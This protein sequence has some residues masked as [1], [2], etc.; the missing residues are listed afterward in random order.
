VTKQAMKAL[1]LVGGFGTRLRPLTLSKPKPLVEF[2]NKPI[3]QHQIEAL[4][5]VRD[6]RALSGWLA[7]SL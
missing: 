6:L 4:A 1:I 7:P 5:K 3:V 2:A